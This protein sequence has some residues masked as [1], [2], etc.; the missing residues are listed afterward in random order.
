MGWNTFWAKALTVVVSLLLRSLYFSL[1]VSLLPMNAEEEK[2]MPPT[3]REISS[4]CSVAANK[5]GRLYPMFD[6]LEGAFLG[7]PQ[8]CDLRAFGSNDDEKHFCK[9]L[10]NRGEKACT[11]ISIGGNN[12]WAF[13]LDVFRYTDCFINTFDCTIDPKVP[14]ELETS[15][16]FKFKKACLGNN[17]TM[18][19]V[20]SGINKDTKMKNLMTWEEIAKDASE[21]GARNI[22]L[23][24]MDIEGWEYEAMHQIGNVNDNYRPLQIA[25]ELHR[26][27]HTVYRAPNFVPSSKKPSKSS[28]PKGLFQQFIEGDL[29]KAGYAIADRN[30]NPFC[31]HCSEVLLLHKDVYKETWKCLKSRN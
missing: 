15:G 11:V 7:A 21:N 31:S 20:H 10:M 25:V 28:Y 8:D 16:R 23:L 26:A 17:S 14:Q 27:T 24:K 4:S 30:D 18:R 5:N 9:A 19:V 22:G 3:L 29:K 2:K 13:E 6:V 1:T 12:E